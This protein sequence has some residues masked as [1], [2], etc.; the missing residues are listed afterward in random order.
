MTQEVKDETQE[1]IDGAPS[2]EAKPSSES[3]V[4][5][6]ERPKNTELLEAQSKIEAVDKILDELGYDSLEDLTS[7]HKGILELKALMGERDANAVIKDYEEYQRVKDYWAKEEE[8]KKRADEEPE[9]TVKRL[10]KEKQELEK[11]IRERE[12]QENR[13]KAEKQQAEEAEKA[14]KR[15]ESTVTSEISSTSDIPEEYVPYLKE[16]MGVGSPANEI[17]ITSKLET[18][19]MAKS[20]IKRFRELE[21]LIIKR[22]KDGKTDLPPITP[23]DAGQAPV[24]AKAKVETLKQAKEIMRERL[25]DLPFFKT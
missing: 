24:K 19:N 12:K 10:E 15:F 17:D 7:T 13:Q 5:A 25:K 3:E 20:Q 6:E 23:T 4:K 11:T 2:E 21:Q 8:R 18:K 1:V 9:D 14:L 22:Y 16:F